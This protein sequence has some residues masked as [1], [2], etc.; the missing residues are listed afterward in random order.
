LKQ[1]QQTDREEERRLG[2]KQAANQLPDE[3]ANAQKRLERLQQA[4]MELEQEAQA[5]LK[6]ALENY[7]PGKRGPRK[8]SEQTSQP[9]KDRRQ[10]DRRRSGA[11]ERERMPLH[12]AGNITS[13]TLIRG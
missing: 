6:A 4:K 2:L 1:A 3:L 5:E 10:R 11:Y 8:K 9:P 12:P 13:S 7:S